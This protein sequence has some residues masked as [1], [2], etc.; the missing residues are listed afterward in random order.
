MC[1]VQTVGEV[2]WLR[3]VAALALVRDKF[4][5]RDRPAAED[6]F[7]AE[8]LPLAQLHETLEESTTFIF[9]QYLPI[10]KIYAS[11]ND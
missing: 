2:D 11:C 10:D 1:E 6:Q 9:S 4:L 8:I 5:E 7:L 3:C